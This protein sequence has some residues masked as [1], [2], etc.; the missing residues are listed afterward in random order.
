MRLFVKRNIALL[1]LFKAI[2]PHEKRRQSS[3]AEQV[4]FS[5]FPAYVRL[6]IPLQTIINV[7]SALSHPCREGKEK[8]LE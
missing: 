1:D 5:R 6:G 2:L 8:K 7:D 4:F 3:P